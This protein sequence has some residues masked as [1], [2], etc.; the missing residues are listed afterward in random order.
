MRGS[1]YLICLR[2]RSNSYKAATEKVRQSKTGGVHGSKATTI[3][4]TVALQAERADIRQ[5]RYFSDLCEWRVRPGYCGAPPRT[6]YVS[7]V[8]YTRTVKG[9]R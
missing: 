3:R 5:T 8:A 6:L 9:Q 7:T 2:K 4:Q 1:Y